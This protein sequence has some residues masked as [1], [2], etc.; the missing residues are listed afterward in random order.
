M[1]IDSNNYDVKYY[2]HSASEDYWDGESFSDMDDAVEDA[3]DKAIDTGC[4][5]DITEVLERH[6]KIVHI[7]VQVLDV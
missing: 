7:M 3:K 1:L 5:H 2:V 4:N 6:R